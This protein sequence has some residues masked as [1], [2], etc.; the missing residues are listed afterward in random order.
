MNNKEFYVVKKQFFRKGF[1]FKPFL[2]KLILTDHVKPTIAE[3]QKFLNLVTKNQE[4]DFSDDEQLVEQAI[5]KTYM[6]GNSIDTT[7]GDKIKVI[8][9]DLKG[10]DGTVVSM[11]DGFVIFKPNME[12]YD[13]NLKLETSNITKFF[14]PG[15]AVRILEGKYKGETGLVTGFEDAQALIALDQRQKEIKIFGNHL[16]LKSEV[17]ISTQ[18]AILN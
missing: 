9:G 17:D 2:K 6:D 14:E 12:G 16:K 4:L 11:E 1:I 8:A 10:L 5:R 7:K 13:Q 3:S 15:D 18:A